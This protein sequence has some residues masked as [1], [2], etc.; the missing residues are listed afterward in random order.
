MSELAREDE[1]IIRKWLAEQAGEVS[2][3]GYIKPAAQYFSGIEEFFATADPSKDTRDEIET[4][5]IAATW[6]Y[7]ANFIDDFTSGGRDSPFVNWR[8][9]FYLFR[10]YGQMRAD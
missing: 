2:E 5:L 6:L 7:P 3:A 9:E 1:Y 8:Y 10:Q 4:S